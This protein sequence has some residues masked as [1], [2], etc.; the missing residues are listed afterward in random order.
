MTIVFSKS[1]VDLDD[2]KTFIQIGTEN[3][4]YII[5]KNNIKQNSLNVN[6]N[7]L[8][9]IDQRNNNNPMFFEYAL[10]RENSSNALYVVV[11]INMYSD[12]VYAKLI[13]IEN[14]SKYY[15]IIKRKV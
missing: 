2:T 15:S 13:P 6:V 11:G 14:A 12:D 5:P 7:D 8:E 1:I 4:Y 10:I 9:L 3:E